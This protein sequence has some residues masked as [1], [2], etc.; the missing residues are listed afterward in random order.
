VSDYGGSRALVELEA[1]C[2]SLAE[3]PVDD[4]LAREGVTT[5]AFFSG[6]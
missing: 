4:A 5:L 2:E 1:L 3:L 6:R